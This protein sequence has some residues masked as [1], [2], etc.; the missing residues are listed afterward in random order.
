MYIAIPT[1]LY[2]ALSLYEQYAAASYCPDVDGGKPGI[3]ITC[4]TGNCPL[5]TA[6]NSSIVLGI[7][8]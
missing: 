7:P 8:T 1:E 3:P 6:A 4:S 2:N 5:V